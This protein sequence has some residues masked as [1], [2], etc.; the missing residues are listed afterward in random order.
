MVPIDKPLGQGTNLQS[1]TFRVDI[2]LTNYHLCLRRAAIDQLTMVHQQPVLGIVGAPEISWAL[3][4][5][6]A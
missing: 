3:A 2:V 1:P 5:T 6:K 4:A